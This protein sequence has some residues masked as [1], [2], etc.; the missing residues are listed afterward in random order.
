VIGQARPAALR[1]SGCCRYPKRAIGAAAAA[2]RL[3]GDAVLAR[4]KRYSGDLPQR[5]EEAS[6]SPVYGAAL[7]MRFGFTPI[8]G[9]NPRASADHGSS[10]CIAGERVARLLGHRFAVWVAVA[11]IAGPQR[12]AHPLARVLHL[13]RRHVGVA[14]C[15][16]HP[17]M[18]GDLLNNADVHALFDNERRCCMPRV[19]NPDVPDLCLTENRAPPEIL[20]ADRAW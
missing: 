8:R 11:L 19:V 12:L 4:A 7:L 9:S 2:V 5:A 20:S 18:T 15:R 13:E 16:R 3:R 17:R 10:P 1:W 6:P 14:L